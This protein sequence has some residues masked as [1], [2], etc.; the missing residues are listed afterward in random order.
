MHLGLV[1]IPCRIA[2]SLFS[3]RLKGAISPLKALA[4]TPPLLFGEASF[5]R[6]LLQWARARAEEP[7]REESSPRI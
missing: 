4:F 2:T 1:V 7:C 5:S 6:S 3:F